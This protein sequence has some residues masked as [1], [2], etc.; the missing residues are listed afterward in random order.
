MNSVKLDKL[1]S[2]ACNCNASVILPDME[3]KHVSLAVNVLVSGEMDM[4]EHIKDIVSP[5]FDILE[6]VS[7][8]TMADKDC[9]VLD[10]ARGNVTKGICFDFLWIGVLNAL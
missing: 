8:Y 9:K 5:I 1:F 7:P 6:M 4:M 2:E 3:V 10:Y